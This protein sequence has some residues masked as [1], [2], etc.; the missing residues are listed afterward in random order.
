MG[1][2]ELP[3]EN[4]SPEFVTRKSLVQ[5]SA[6]QMI[7]TYF[8]KFSHDLNDI[9]FLF[10]LVVEIGAHRVTLSSKEE[11]LIKYFRREITN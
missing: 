6:L 3:I 7:N 2:K 1:T 10:V 5:K 4:R 9:W 11:K 8:S